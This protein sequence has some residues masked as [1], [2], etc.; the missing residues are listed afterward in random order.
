MQVHLSKPALLFLRIKNI[1]KLLKTM[2]KNLKHSNLLFLYLSLQF[3]SLVA[4]VKGDISDSFNKLIPRTTSKCFTF[5]SETYFIHTLHFLLIN[6]TIH[7][8]SFCKTQHTFS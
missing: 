3:F 8:Y 6:L 4:L 1:F 7:Y 5:V 2:I